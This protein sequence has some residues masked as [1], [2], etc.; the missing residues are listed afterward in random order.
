MPAQR[1]VMPGRHGLEQITGVSMLISRLFEAVQYKSGDQTGT[2][3]ADG[4]GSRRVDAKSA[5]L[6]YPTGVADSNQTHS[7]SLNWQQLCPARRQATTLT[8]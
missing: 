7:F 6:G 3:H 5:R 1:Q 2:A 8:V 4:L